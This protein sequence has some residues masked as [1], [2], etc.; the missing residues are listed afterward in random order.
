MI[1]NSTFNTDVYERAVISFKTQRRVLVKYGK[2][3]K[4]KITRYYVLQNE[5]LLYYK[6]SKCEKSISSFSLA[7]CSY[8]RDTSKIK[9]INQSIKVVTSDNK[10]TF[11]LHPISND[12]LP[13]L[14]RYIKFV[15]EGKFNNDQVI[16]QL[17]ID[18]LSKQEK[19][20]S[21]YSSH[22]QIAF[23]TANQVSIQNTHINRSSQQYNQETIQIGKLQT[24]V[25]RFL[26]GNQAY[27][28]ECSSENIKNNINMSYYSQ[29]RQLEPQTI[30]FQIQTAEDK[31]QQQK[32]CELKQIEIEQIQKQ[33]EIS[34]TE[35]QLSKQSTL[36]EKQKTVNAGEEQIEFSKINQ[37]ANQNSQREQC[38]TNLIQQKQFVKFQVTQRSL[39]DKADQQNQ[40][41]CEEEQLQVYQQL[42]RSII[43]PNFNQ[44]Q[45]NQGNLQNQNNLNQQNNEYLVT[46]GQMSQNNMFTNQANMSV[47]NKQNISYEKFNGNTISQIFKNMDNNF[48]PNPIVES[49]NFISSPG[50][51]K[52]N[53]LQDNSQNV[54]AIIDKD[55]SAIIKPN[56][57]SNYLDIDADLKFSS[58]EEYS[59][60]KNEKLE[61]VRLKYE[62][63]SPNANKG[64]LIGHNLQNSSIFNQTNI[65]KN[66]KI[67]QQL[68]NQ[69]STK[70]FQENNEAENII[71]T[72]TNN[73][74]ININKNNNNNINYNNQNNNG[75][76]FGTSNMSNVPSSKQLSGNPTCST[77]ATQ[78]VISPQMKQLRYSNSLNNMQNLQNH[79]VDHNR[80]IQLGPC[81]LSSSTLQNI[82]FPESQKYYTE[83][84]Q[85]SFFSHKVD[86]NTNFQDAANNSTNQRFLQQKQKLVKDHANLSDVHDLS[87]QENISSD[88]EEIV[89]STQFFIK[90]QVFYA[91]ASK[92]FM[93][94]GFSSS[95]LPQQSQRNSRIGVISN[96][97]FDNKTMSDTDLFDQV[98]GNFQ[99]SA[100]D[101]IQN[102]EENQRKAK[103]SK[104]ASENLHSKSA[105]LI[106]QHLAQQKN[107]QK[108]HE[109]QNQQQKNP[110]YMK[111]LQAKT[112]LRYVES[113][114]AGVQIERQD[115]QLQDLIYRDQQV[116]EDAGNY[117]D[118]DDDTNPAIANNVTYIIEKYK[119][120]N[121]NEKNTGL[122]N[123][124]GNNYVKKTD[125]ST[126][127]SQ[128]NQVKKENSDKKNQKRM[129]NHMHTKST[130]G[131]RQNASNSKRSLSNV[132]ID[133]DKCNIEYTQNTHKEPQIK[134]KKEFYNKKNI[135][136]YIVPKM[137]DV[138]PY[139]NYQQDQHSK[140]VNKQISVEKC[141]SDGYYYLWSFQFA[142]SHE[143]F[144]IHREEN[145]NFEYALLEHNLLKIIV[146]GKKDL[147]ATTEQKF[148]EFYEYLIACQKDVQKKG[149]KSTIKCLSG[150]SQMMID[151][152]KSETYLVRGLLQAFLNNK[153][154]SFIQFKNAYQTFQKVKQKIESSVPKN[155]SIH[156]YLK[157]ECDIYTKSRFYFISG[158]FNIGLSMIPSYFLKI[159][160]LIGIQPN[161]Q[162]GYECLEKCIELQSIRSSYASLLLCI[163]YIELNPNVEKSIILIKKM[164]KTLPQCP[165]FYWMA[166][167]LS[168][169]YTKPDDAL[170]LINK[171]LW[172]CGEEL[173][174]ISFYLKFEKG[175]YNVSQFD[176]KQALDLFQ[177]IVVMAIDVDNFDM[178]L[179]SSLAHQKKLPEAPKLMMQF[180]EE[181]K[182]KFKQKHKIILPHKCCLVALVACCYENQG[183]IDNMDLWFLMTQYLI[184][185]NQDHK[186]GV[187][188]DIS[189]LCAKYINRQNKQLI[190][191]EIL[192]FVKEITKLREDMLNKMVEE[193][194]FYYESEY[195][196]IQD[197][198]YKN[199][200]KNN[201]QKAI[202]FG[203]TIFLRIV[204]GCLQQ[205]FNMVYQSGKILDKIAE[206]IPVDHHYILHHSYHW[207]ARC[208]LQQSLFSNS[209]ENLKK[210]LKYKKC[211]FTLENKSQKLLQEID[212]AK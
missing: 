24:Q 9:K 152:I 171:S 59:Q 27:E 94:D 5:F 146:T 106:N 33:Q 25:N 130:T 147:I 142:N 14:E 154:Q 168:W 40:R 201:S 193:I 177:E 86:T 194:Q 111:N 151:L 48:S 18:P 105:S 1:E 51:F 162:Y 144:K 39:N 210:C 79:Q 53:S 82:F 16:Q 167:L 28:E 20:T 161:K 121:Y 175:W 22:L 126:M 138:I 204:S 145:I 122:F 208:Q 101:I 29:M 61:S 41:I 58:D 75:F 158:L 165:L 26:N 19:L 8:S 191:Y 93:E 55:I 180:I 132:T 62:S 69:V 34:Q 98:E 78:N 96:Y 200:L 117:L 47:D 153:F 179:F 159:L 76:F 128:E 114:T 136:G 173:G 37:M 10:K 97:S 80:N 66:Y 190:K 109:D 156:E 91:G 70:L 119:E 32:Q 88:D 49:G 56:D 196:S 108:I 127:I 3:S 170:S 150:I 163:E 54:Q 31:F 176:W 60:N 124:N 45:G 30:G 68:L 7:S 140:N 103:Q 148:A 186:T 178:D 155:S 123:A 102:E 149:D 139:L 207:L 135:I 131:F 95:A 81:N 137:E 6:N 212:F 164:I 143:I 92:M 99:K 12:E 90:Q 43:S 206:F 169:R 189:K 182:N 63:L 181:A 36:Q 100:I 172:N 188:E 87:E 129:N 13:L 65:N 44:L 35:N 116:D 134:D 112:N 42:R 17:L 160:S 115:N 198:F 120:Q 197:I 15:S 199:I 211:E 2:V 85:G 185:K 83:S 4:F 195:S 38:Y 125:L 209:K 50:N 57:H 107:Q 118:E 74:N 174:Q 110:L 133:T 192:Y 67:N 183:L 46:L 21:A 89:P 84:P 52:I 203:S 71:I 205:D 202:D 157:K 64:Y 166:S 187:D 113:S 73:N 11:W 23:T 184:K 141:Y 77:Q 72:T 104:R